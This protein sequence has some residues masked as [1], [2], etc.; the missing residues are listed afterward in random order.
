[1]WSYYPELTALELKN[2]LLSSVASHANLKVN[3]PNKDSQTKTIVRFK[4]LCKTGG[5]VNAYKALKAADKF[6]KKKK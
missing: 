3:Q 4:T 6:V 5:S 1:V 2:I